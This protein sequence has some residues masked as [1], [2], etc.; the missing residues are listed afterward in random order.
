[1]T[2][3]VPSNNR[4]RAETL[5]DNG[6]LFVATHIQDN[7]VDGGTAEWRISTSTDLPLSNRLNLNSEGKI[8]VEIFEGADLTGGNN[9][10]FM[11]N[12]NRTSNK[13][14]GTD[15][16]DSPTVNDVGVKISEQVFGSTGVAQNTKAGGVSEGSKFIFK[17]DTEYLVR[18]TNQSSTESDIGF[19]SEF[20]ERK[21]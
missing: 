19:L 20:F 6:D 17:P 13:T 2:R 18:V 11:E 21:I 16:L 8:L 4:T 1:M 15:V 10:V 5:T 9:N 12:L 7:I 14:P 3:R